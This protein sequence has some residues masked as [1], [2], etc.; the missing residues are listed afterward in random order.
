MVEKILYIR[1]NASVEE[2]L[3]EEIKAIRAFVMKETK[4]K[5]VEK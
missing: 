5:E 4:E 2:Q 3:P 1:L